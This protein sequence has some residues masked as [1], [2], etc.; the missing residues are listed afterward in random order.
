MLGNAINTG[1][2]VQIETY[3]PDVTFGQRSKHPFW[4]A[5]TPGREAS[6]I[7][8]RCENKNV[9]MSDI[10]IKTQTTYSKDVKTT[11]RRTTEH[12]HQESS[13]SAKEVLR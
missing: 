9:S 8:S 3:S 7:L 12:P 6:S 5:N 10:H 13:S 1:T 2:S 11:D 4:D